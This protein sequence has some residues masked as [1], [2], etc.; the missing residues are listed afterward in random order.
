LNIDTVFRKV[1]IVGGPTS[2]PENHL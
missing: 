2:A 1:I